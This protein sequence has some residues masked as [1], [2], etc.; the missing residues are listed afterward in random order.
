MWSHSGPTGAGE[1]AAA[2]GVGTLVLT[3]LGPYTSAQPAVDM[4][5]KNRA[6]GELL[7]WAR[8]EGVRIHTVD[9]R[10]PS[11]PSVQPAGGRGKVSP[12]P[13]RG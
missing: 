7:R 2:A 1:T 13:S 11:A 6:L 4:A 12:S 9:V 5:A 8:G 3:H 10:V